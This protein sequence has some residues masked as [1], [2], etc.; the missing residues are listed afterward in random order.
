MFDEFARNLEREMA[1]GGDAAAD[2]AGTGTDTGTDA[3]ATPGPPERE[4]P[5][6]SRAPE[7]RSEAGD[8]PA[9]DPMS[10]FVTPALK[11]ALP[12][13]GPALIGLGYGYL[14]GRL[15]ELRR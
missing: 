14:L 2:A 9:L 15:R 3:D 1:G 11:K 10:L 12:V 4:Q 6:A 13:L 7:R 5:A 8:S